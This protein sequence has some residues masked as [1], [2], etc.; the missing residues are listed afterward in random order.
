VEQLN[1]ASFR[2][3]PALPANIRQGRKG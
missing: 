3:A 1:G 2:Q